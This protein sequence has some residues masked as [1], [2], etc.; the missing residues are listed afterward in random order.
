MTHRSSWSRQA[1]R[2][3]Q[4][5]WSSRNSAFPSTGLAIGCAP[6]EPLCACARMNAVGW[7]PWRVGGCTGLVVRS[8]SR[9][10]PFVQQPACRSS[11]SSSVAWSGSLRE[12]QWRPTCELR[13]TMGSSAPVISFPSATAEPES[14]QPRALACRPGRSPRRGEACTRTLPAERRRT[15][16]TR[17]PERM[18]P[19]SAG[20]KAARRFVEA[21]LTGPDE[22]ARADRCP[23]MAIAA[24]RRP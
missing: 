1:N 18:P 7:Q 6:E 5:L 10:P 17:D 3:P 16:K 23:P 24:G 15:G 14:G 11:G 9:S 13:L 20:P 12:P 8:Q 4:L 21:P 22:G 2:M 19:A